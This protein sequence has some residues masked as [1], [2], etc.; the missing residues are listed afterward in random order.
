MTN[1]NEYLL[2]KNKTNVVTIPEK[3]CTIEEICAWLAY[4]GVE[5]QREFKITPR[6]DIPKKGKLLVRVSRNNKNKSK[7]YWVKLVACNNQQVIFKPL[8]SC[9]FLN[10]G[11]HEYKIS[12]EKAVE[13]AKDMIDNPNKI[14]DI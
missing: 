1:I 9:S 14:I 4:M 2:T 13:I 8:D 6:L 5:D 7:E 3:G 11:L 12:F 10:L